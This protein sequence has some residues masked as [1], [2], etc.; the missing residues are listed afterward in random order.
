MASDVVFYE[1]VIFF[2]PPLFEGERSDVFQSLDKHMDDV[3]CI[4][5]YQKGKFLVAVNRF[6][7]TSKECSRLSCSFGSVAELKT[8]SHVRCMTPL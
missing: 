2:Q 3:L 7:L 5:F 1:G 8:I 6:Y 4:S